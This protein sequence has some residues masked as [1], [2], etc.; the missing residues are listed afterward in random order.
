MASG[1]GGVLGVVARAGRHALLCFVFLL[2]GGCSLS[3]APILDPKG[4]VALA[5][6]DLL[7]TAAL[8]MLIVIVPVFVMAFIF[9]WRY[10]ASGGRGRYRPDWSYSVP[11]DAVVWLVPV[12][13]V[14]ALGV[15]LSRGAADGGDCHADPVLG[16]IRKAVPQSRAEPTAS[17]FSFADAASLPRKLRS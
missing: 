3:R 6:R 14:V 13:I 9:A 8:V 16:L 11:V 7:F 1:K 2:V 12:A 4:P 15:F 10:R 5:E 17:G